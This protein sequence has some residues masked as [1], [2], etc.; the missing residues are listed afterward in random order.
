MQ[1]TKDKDLY[2]KGGWEAGPKSA[3]VGWGEEGRAAS[4]QPASM[5]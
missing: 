4:Q 1:R 5:K 3:L 2:Y